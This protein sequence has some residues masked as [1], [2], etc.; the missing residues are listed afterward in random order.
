MSG[1]KFRRLMILINK[2]SG[3]EV[4]ILVCI[5]MNTIVLTLE[6]YEAPSRLEQIKDIINNVFTGIF[7]LEA[8]IK[9]TALGK[10]YF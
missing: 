5:I 1:S 10:R 9:I 7:T 6:W 4:I 3:F 8:I 2:S